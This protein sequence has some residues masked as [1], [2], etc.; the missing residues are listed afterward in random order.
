MNELELEAAAALD[1]R[2]EAV[3]AGAAAALARRELVEALQEE[4][5]SVFDGAFALEASAYELGA[6]GQAVR[7]PWRFAVADPGDSLRSL[8][9]SPEAVD[10]VSRIQGEPMAPSKASYLYFRDDSDFIGFHT[11]VPSCQVVLLVG[12]TAENADLVLYPDFEHS[13]PSEL[14][15]L[16]RRADGAPGGGTALPVERGHLT[17]LVGRRVPHMTPRARRSGPVVQAS[18]CYAGRG[19]AR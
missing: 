6:E 3:G 5:A 10:L 4:A 11:D 9:E 8:H 17:A 13:D 18:L 7:S 1:R 14:L 19:A 2:L 16:S 12:I 15:E